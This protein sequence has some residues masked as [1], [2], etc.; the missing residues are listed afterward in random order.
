[1]VIRF[2]FSFVFFVSF[3]VKG[4]LRLGLKLSSAFHRLQHGHFV[5]ILDVAAGRNSGRN[6][7]DLD[8]G[9]LQ[10]TSKMDRCSF[11]FN[12]WIRCDDHFIQAATLNPAH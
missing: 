8:A 4:S 10:Q 5:R 1:V 11:A 2:L 6:A 9:T 12:R 3:V 7:G